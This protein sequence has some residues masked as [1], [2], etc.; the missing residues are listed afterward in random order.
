MLDLLAKK[1]MRGIPGSLGPDPMCLLADQRCLGRAVFDCS[2]KD[3][4]V[5][6]HRWMKQGG[7]C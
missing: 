3:W 6:R 4:E 7:Y 2:L 1:H 5:S